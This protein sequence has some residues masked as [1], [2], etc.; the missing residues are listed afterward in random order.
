MAR[1][2][3]VGDDE[4]Q[5]S[6]PASEAAA[7]SRRRH[8][9]VAAG[10]ALAIPG[11]E[12][13]PPLLR[14]FWRMVR[15]AYGAGAGDDP[16]LGRVTGFAQAPQSPTRRSAPPT[17]CCGRVHGGGSRNGCRAIHRGK[18]AAWPGS[19]RRS[20]FYWWKAVTTTAAA[21]NPSARSVR[22]ARQRHPS[23]SR[24]SLSP[25]HSAVRCQPHIAPAPAHCGSP[26]GPWAPPYHSDTRSPGRGPRAAIAILHALYR[27]GMRQWA[28]G[29]WQ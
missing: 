20:G 8:T 2:A 13:R 16:Q 21:G 28:K 5:R 18:V 10:L 19:C 1:V 27:P 7:K 9:H 6:R 14:R 24:H 17:N 29:A 25:G 22:M 11:H 12:A 15:A 26:H 4:S 23:T 3:V